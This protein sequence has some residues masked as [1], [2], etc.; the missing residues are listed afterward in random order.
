VKTPPLRSQNRFEGL[1]V[2]DMDDSD[3]DTMDTV[4]VPTSSDSNSTK[5]AR[6]TDENQPGVPETCLIPKPIESKLVTSPKEGEKYFIRSAR[7]AREI[8]LKITITTLD[9]HDTIGFMALLDSGAT[10]LFIDRGFVHRNGLK[11]RALDQPIKVYNVDGT[12]NQGGSITE[13][14]TLMISHKGHKEKAVFEVCDLGKSAVILGHPWLRKHNPEI[15]WQT[16]EVKMSRCPRECNV[17]IRAATKERKQRKLAEKW[18][19]KATVEEVED[20]EEFVRR[21]GTMMEDDGILEEIVE[22]VFIR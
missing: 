21:G 17:W 19:Y 2:D 7:I 14:I 13:E 1:K 5:M 10:G 11:T 8:N 20:E 4:V 9:T 15:N 22:E 6:G 3:N 16:G 18:K 12:L